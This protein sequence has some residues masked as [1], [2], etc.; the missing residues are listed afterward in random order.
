MV[1]VPER[2]TA[3]TS[4]GPGWRVDGHG[5][6]LYSTSA[7]K[8][9]TGVWVTGNGN[10]V[11]IGT[12]ADNNG[13]GIR[14][15]G[16]GNTVTGP[17]VL[18]NSGDGIQI[19]GHNNTVLRADVGVATRGNGGDGISVNGRGN[20]LRRNSVFGNVGDGI[21]VTGGTAAAPNVIAENLAGDR[22]K[23][24]GGHGIFVFADVG[25]GNGGT[26][27]ID[28]NT[29]RDNALDGIH[30][31]A[32]ATGHDLRNNVS[33]GTAAQSN[34]GCEFNVAPGNFNRSGNKAN[35]TTVAGAMGSPFPTG[36]LGTP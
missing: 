25:S 19:T 34:E 12:Y 2:L 6:Y 1:R 10:T 16:D 27:E 31:A 4:S 8:T 24:N 9:A 32:S 3:S 5:R 7:S 11:D 17:L 15:T 14:V 29:V 21:A 30:L 28:K 22:S 23:D 26:I 33:G 13:V 35:A 20:A 18:T 36:C